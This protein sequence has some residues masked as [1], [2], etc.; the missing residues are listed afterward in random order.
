MPIRGLPCDFLTIHPFAV[1]TFHLPTKH[2]NYILIRGEGWVGFLFSPFVFYFLFFLVFNGPL[3]QNY[4]FALK[5]DGKLD[6]FG[7]QIGLDQILPF[8]EPK[9]G[10]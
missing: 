6:D 1:K 5:M 10:L 4:V 7:S 9:S 3:T 2:V 8:F